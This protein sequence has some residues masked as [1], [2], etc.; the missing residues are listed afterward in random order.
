MTVSDVL[1]VC[2]FRDVFLEEL[3]VIPLEMQV[4]FEIKLTLGATLIAKS[5]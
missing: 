4:R 1:V 5:H 2:E 3:I